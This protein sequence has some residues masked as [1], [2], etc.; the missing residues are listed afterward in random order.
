MSDDDLAPLRLMGERNMPATA[1]AIVLA[2]AAQY[3][4]EP[5]RLFDPWPERRRRPEVEAARSAAIARL[6]NEMIDNRFRYG[7]GEVAEWFGTA[8]QRIHVHRKKAD[9]YRPRFERAR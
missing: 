1:Q 3:E 7:L 9:D 8:R 2:T 4:V 5:L 6:A